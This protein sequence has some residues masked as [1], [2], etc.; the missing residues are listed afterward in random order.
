M[1][2]LEF[3]FKQTDRAENS[4]GHLKLAYGGVKSEKIILMV[5][6]Y[7]PTEDLHTGRLL[8]GPSGEYLFSLMKLAKERFLLDTETKFTW[9]CCA[10]NAYRTVGK[11]DEYV[12]VAQEYFGNRLNAIIEKYKPTSVITFGKKPSEFLNKRDF[13]NC[14]G[15]PVKA[16]VGTHKFVQ[17]NSLSIHQLMRGDTIYLSGYCAKHIA[18]AIAHKHQ[19]LIKPDKATSILVDTNKKFKEMM[20]EITE[21]KVVSV[22]TE[23]TNLNKVQNTLLTIQFATAGTH[24][25]FLPIAHKDTPFSSERISSMKNSLKEYFETNKNKWQVF[26]NATFDLNV[27]RA[28][29]NLDIRYYKSNLADIFCGEFLIEENMKLLQTQGKYYY[30]LANLA[31]QYGSDVYER[32]EFKKSDRATIAERDLDEHLIRYGVYDVVVP[33]L[34][35]EKQVQIAERMGHD[36][37]L[38]NM[39]QISDT[40]HTISRM[41]TCGS[42]VDIEYLFNLRLP[43]SPIKEAIDGIKTKLYASDGVKKAEERLRKTESIPEKAGGWV[44]KDTQQSIFDFGKAKH[45]QMLYFTVLK[46]KPLSRG[47]DKPD[48]KQGDGKLDKTFQKVYKDVPEVKLYSE[49]TKALKL[50]NS[51]VKSF[52]KQ[53][54]KKPDFQKDNRIR[55]SYDY[56][57]VITGRI[58]S[59]DPSLHQIPSRSVLGKHIKRIFIARPGCLY[60]KVDMRSHEVRGWGNIAGDKLIAKVFNDGDALIQQY[61]EKPS[62]ELADRI[63]IEADVHKVN[64]AYFFGIP[65]LEVSKEIRDAVKSLVFGLIYGKSEKSLAEEQGKPLEFITDLVSKFFGRFP[66]GAGWFDYIEQCAKEALFV[67]SPLGL[68]RN[69]Y[70]YMMPESVR[71]SRGVYGSMNRRA[72]N[73]PVQGMSAQLVMTGARLLDRLC[74]K[75]EIDLYINNSVH[76][77]LETECSY[78]DLFKGI[79]YVEHSLCEGAAGIIEK[80]HNWKMLSTPRVD[81]ELGPAL[82]HC[83]NWD[84]D[85]SK[86]E[87]IMLKSVAFQKYVLGHDIEIHDTIEKIFSGFHEGPKWMLTQAKNIGV[88]RFQENKIY[89]SPYRGMKKSKILE[90]TGIEI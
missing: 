21:A 30:S 62:K 69:L 23:T 48:G 60:I 89:T 46:L 70:G 83:E 51:F 45:K 37:F 26:A 57:G 64:A 61:K 11:S 55:P 56:L 65:I 74:Y 13:G 90:I 77:S 6:D 36:G 85:L 24:G 42:L 9:I 75:D 41:E 39:M 15:L 73:S 86:I 7:V 76:D 82:S 5:L 52:I 8:S 54:G 43:G 47:V 18:N 84:Y 4:Y 34:I 63:A 80:R 28:K 78:K 33:L 68:R 58:S 31:M 71:E 38:R 12:A 19:W 3:E 35:H 81:L 49:Y 87:L 67:Q 17:I 40:I 1:K 66:V 27:M 88:K 29:K 79:R 16:K 14:L 20:A 53:Y 2:H 22:D 72:R 59:R 44:T 50:E 10:W 32:G 25:Y